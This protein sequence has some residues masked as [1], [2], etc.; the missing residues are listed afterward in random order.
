MPTHTA[1]GELG[2]A[3]PDTSSPDGIRGETDWQQR[4][5]ADHL[6]DASR[7]PHHPPGQLL[8]R[9]GTMELQVAEARSAAHAGT[10]QA[11]R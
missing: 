11:N 10:S 2:S 7:Q 4:S 6:A 3:Q 1:G 9:L 5:L 8:R